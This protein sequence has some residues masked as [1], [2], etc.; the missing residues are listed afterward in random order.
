MLDT[1]AVLY[2]L[3]G[4]LAA[5]LPPGEYLISVITEMELLSYPSLDSRSEKQ[6]TDFLTEVA[7][8]GLTRDVEERAIQ[9]RQQEHLKLPDAIVA[10]TA[11]VFDAELL[12][13]DKKLHRVQGLKLRELAVRENPLGSS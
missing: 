5:P 13:N 3:G 7:V 8:I 9:L 4:R 12:T 1:N 11:L 10:A 6:I 2:L